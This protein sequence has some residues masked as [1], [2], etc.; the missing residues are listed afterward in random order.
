MTRVEDSLLE[1]IPTLVSKGYPSFE[2][3]M[4]CREVDSALSEADLLLLMQA[5]GETNSM[6]L[7]HCG[8]QALLDHLRAQFPLPDGA[9][10][11]PRY[12][13]LFPPEAEA[14]GVLQAISLARHFDTPI[15][16]HN[17]SSW[18]AMQILSQYHHLVP[19]VHA[20]CSLHHLTHTRNSYQM[21]DGRNYTCSPPLRREGDTQAL[22][23]GLVSGLLQV[24]CSSHRAFTREQKKLG[25]DLAS[26]PEGFANLGALLPVLYHKGVAGKRLSLTQLVGLLSTWPAQIFG[27]SS[28]GAVSV[29]K[30]ADL[31][32][33]DPMERRQLNAAMMHSESD[34]CL[35]E[36]LEVHGGIE[37]TLSRG[38]IV[39][40]RG[41]FVGEQ[42][43]GQFIPRRL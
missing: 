25:S 5:L 2:A 22:W 12:A 3:Y 21:P 36:G 11:I 15:Y 31:V 6:L 10:S 26:I 28:K 30:D 33:F 39:A 35:Y 14:T 32:I 17:L 27:L 40:E 23:A 8:S 41:R 19:R 13:D 38:R 20:G 7:L 4:S 34:F 37:M 42:G 18:D 24:V 43:A 29:G 1:E 9:E 16:L